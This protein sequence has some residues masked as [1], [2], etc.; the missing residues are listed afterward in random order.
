MSDNVA[1]HAELHASSAYSE[2]KRLAANL[3]RRENP[4]HTLGPT[5]LV[6]EAYLRL[7]KQRGSNAEP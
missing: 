5:A 2:L 3:M 6:H 4:G 7:S 1:H